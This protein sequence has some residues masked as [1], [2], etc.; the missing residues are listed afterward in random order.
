MGQCDAAA[1]TVQAT[2][3]ND[4]PVVDLSPLNSADA[5]AIAG[6]VA[7]I[8]KACEEW[9]CFQVINHG[10]PLELQA[11]YEFVMKQF[12]AQ[13]V[14]A[15][16]KLRKDIDIE[17]PYAYGYEE[18]QGNVDDWKEVFDFPL[19]KDPTVQALPEA[20]SEKTRDLIHSWPEY[21]SNFR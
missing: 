6:V 9:G 1:A 21:P 3:A 7:Q 18:F 4:L 2:E 10:V 11:K 8:G 15:K 12:F 13:P 20:E 14:E 5:S 19:E 17:N 16:R